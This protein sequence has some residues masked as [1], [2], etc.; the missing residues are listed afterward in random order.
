MGEKPHKNSFDVLWLT[1]SY[2]AMKK[3]KEEK[4]GEHCR[5][6]SI[7]TQNDY[8]LS[9]YV[10]CH[11]TLGKTHLNPNPALIKWK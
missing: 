1:A 8:L 9:N 3:S 10:T 7:L 11:P 6:L 2:V 4:E 5:G